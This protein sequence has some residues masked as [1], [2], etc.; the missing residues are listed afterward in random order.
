MRF[1]PHPRIPRRRIR[2]PLEAELRMLLVSHYARWIY[3][4]FAAFNVVIQLCTHHWFN[5]VMGLVSGSFY[6]WITHRWICNAVKG[7][8]CRPNMRRVMKGIDKVRPGILRQNE[9]NPALDPHLFANLR[10]AAWFFYLRRK[11]QLRMFP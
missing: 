4:P 5:A 1:P 6:T 10:V 11:H 2:T 9:P 7:A 3:P 8:T